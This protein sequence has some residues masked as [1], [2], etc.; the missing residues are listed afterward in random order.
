MHFS[1]NVYV[2]MYCAFLKEILVTALARVKH[3]D[4]SNSVDA[5]RKKDDP[6][7]ECGHIGKVELK[8]L[9]RNFT[10]SVPFLHILVFTSRHVGR[11]SSATGH[12]A[13]VKKEEK[14]EGERTESAKLQKS[15]QQQRSADETKL[16]NAIWQH[17]ICALLLCKPSVTNNH[18]IN[19]RSRASS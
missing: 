8:A 5:V 10:S 15:S 17:V 12:A 6:D 1:I 9:C 16:A 3:V 4:A 11:V 18:L 7:E 13:S 14:K 2:Y 19:V